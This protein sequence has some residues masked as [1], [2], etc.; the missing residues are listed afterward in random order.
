MRDNKSA[1]LPNKEFTM[2]RTPCLNRL[3]PVVIEASVKTVTVGERNGD[4]FHPLPREPNMYAKI[5]LV[6]E[7]LPGGRAKKRVRH[8]TPSG[9]MT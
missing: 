6:S 8:I 5:Y 1:K 3:N 9:G 7:P 4:I 2:Y